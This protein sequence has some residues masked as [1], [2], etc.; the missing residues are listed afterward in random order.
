MRILFSAVAVAL[1]LA[2]SPRQSVAQLEVTPA[3]G[4]YFPIGAL[5]SGNHANGGEVRRHIPAGSI[6]LRMAV[7]P[8]HRFGIEG[9][10]VFSP[11]QVAWEENGRVV[12]VNSGVFFAGVRGVFSLSPNTAVNT[13]RFGAGVGL[14]SRGG[15]AWT[16]TTGRTM[17]ALNLA[18]TARFKL[19]RGP[20]ALLFQLEDYVG[21]AKLDSGSSLG[22]QA[23][24]HHD[25][26]WTLGLAMRVR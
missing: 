9:S 11:S 16:N 23:R 7:W 1:L 22:T 18:A 12:D 14:V 21:T 25:I 15:S 8:A 10:V 13:V 26:L 3:L 17:P 5:I 24:I 4:M 20:L 2:V 6:G 19:G